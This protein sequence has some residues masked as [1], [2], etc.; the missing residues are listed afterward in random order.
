MA[1]RTGCVSGIGAD[2]DVGPLHDRLGVG[3]NELGFGSTRAPQ[4]REG[5]G[6]GAE[7]VGMAFGRSRQEARR[8]R[9][10]SG[11]RR[12]W[13][14]CRCRRPPR[15]WWVG[16]SWRGWSRSLP[17]LP[18]NDLPQWFAVQGRVCRRRNPASSGRSRVPWR[19]RP[20][21]AARCP[22]EKRRS[23]RYPS[24]RRG[25]QRQ[26]RQGDAHIHGVTGYLAR[27]DALRHQA[28]P[29]YHHRFRD[30]PLLSAGL[31][32]QAAQF[33]VTDHDELPRLPV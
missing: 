33:G 28:Y 10:M 11:R 15:R 5:Y 2:N 23:S 4:P 16:R 31:D 7:Y 8:T 20:V 26:V 22:D 6:T 25:R 9:L 27:H 30:E 1:A 21:P 14:G 12:R 19:A 17:L 3:G 24:P 18:Q 29:G 13:P 32:Q